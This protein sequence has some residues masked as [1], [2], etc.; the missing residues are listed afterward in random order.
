M[1]AAEVP[2]NGYYAEDGRHVCRCG[3]HTRYAAMSGGREFYCEGCGNNGFYPDG[4]GGPRA[5]LLDAGP[6]GIAL[7]RAQMDQ[8]IAR[9][10][11]R[12]Q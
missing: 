10:K 6:D 4:D 2:W 5:R 9:R 3:A 12:G 1:T 7:L 11:D 8:E